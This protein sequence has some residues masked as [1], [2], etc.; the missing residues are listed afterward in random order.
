MDITEFEYLDPERVD[1]VSGPA[2]G[3]PFLMLKSL[4]EDEGEVFSEDG[5]V[6][7]V[8][9][10]A[11]RKYAK[12]GVA[13]PDG[14][15]PIAD[16][17][18]LRSAIGRLG[19][20][21]G[22]KAAAKRHIIKRA[23]ALGLTHL[24]PEDWHVS[25]GAEAEKAMSDTQDGVQGREKGANVD[26]SLGQTRANGD[27][28][29][30]HG[31]VQNDEGKPQM[32]K[33]S[34]PRPDEHTGYGDTA[35]D[36]SLPESEALSQTREEHAEKNSIGPNEASSEGTVAPNRK[37]D[38]ARAERVG[39]DQTRQVH[40][41]EGEAE[42]N[43][44]QLRLQEAQSQKARKPKKHIAADNPDAKADSD[45]GNPAWQ[46]KDVAL[47]AEA[48]AHLREALSLAAQFEAREKREAKKATKRINAAVASLSTVSTS[49]AA[50]EIDDMTTE[51]LMKLLDERD[52]A[53][54]AKAAKAAKKE[55]KR[56]AK[57]AKKAAKAD[58]TSEDAAESLSK[59]V[60]ALE[61]VPVRRAAMNDHADPSARPVL[62][63]A[64]QPQGGFETLQKA[65][66]AAHTPQERLALQ[67]EFIKAKYLAN[68][69]I[70]VPTDGAGNALAHGPVAL[71]SQPPE[72]FANARAAMGR[73]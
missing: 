7:F 61:S 56:A 68:N 12:E 26:D 51:E 42:P 49:A 71:V 8:S 45:P 5:L 18:H 29:V 46:D 39:E 10:A 27:D 50:K 62:R 31:D 13:M 58:G 70:Q 41:G 4:D 20:Y 53:K 32:G 3:T 66:D 72:A 35:P 9:A 73:R 60:L 48:V 65:L 25:K 23:K 69:E 38:T 22:D 11:R 55:A 44:E 40:E 57:A 52:R 2:N 24:L 6:K 21:K 37:R 36:K 47:A 1:A 19:N 33:Y 16:E 14:A 43:A 17:G 63:G 34:Q 67:R 54:E 64:S 30:V 59:R 15:F 28:E